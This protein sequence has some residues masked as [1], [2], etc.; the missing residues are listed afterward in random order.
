MD[1][2]YFTLSPWEQ[3]L[4]ITFNYV[5]SA[6]LLFIAMMFLKLAIMQSYKK[7]DF[8]KRFDCELN[9]QE[10]NMRSN[11]FYQLSYVFQGFALFCTTFPANF[12]VTEL[13]V[14]IQTLAV[15]SVVFMVFVA[16]TKTS[17]HLILHNIFLLLVLSCASSMIIIISSQRNIVLMFY[18]EWFLIGFIVSGAITFIFVCAKY[19]RKTLLVIIE[20]I[21]LYTI[22]TAM[23][24]LQI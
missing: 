5:M 9:R 15:L 24:I 11:H 17:N 23:V 4:R 14:Q 6:V 20:R 22:F 8:W 10:N 19:T 18:Y 3:A 7:F 1:R 13:I 12:L 21:C 16:I 2:N